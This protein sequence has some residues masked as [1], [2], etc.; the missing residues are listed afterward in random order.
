MRVYL[1]LLFISLASTLLLTPLVRRVALGLNVLTPLRDRDVHTVPRPRLGGLALTGGIVLTLVV[2]YSIPF[3][4][5][6]YEFSPALWAV[7]GGSVA[8]CLLGAIDDIWEL[9]W[10]A[11]LAGQ[12]IIAGAM[13]MMG[14]QLINIPLFGVTIGSPR[15]S[16]LLSTLILV[17][18]MNAV[19]FVDGLDGLAA[20]VIGIGSLGFF[21]YSYLLTRLM[22]AP[23]YAT[24]A[25]VVTIALAGVCIGFLWFNFHPASIFM[26]DSGAMVLGL[27][28]GSAAIIVT[29]QLNPALLAEHSV[30]TSWMPLILP[31]AVL[32]IPL[33]DL[34]ITPVLRML[35][36]KSPVTADRTHLHD[37][38]LIAGHS[39]RGVVLILYAWTALACGTA[40]A[41]ILLPLSTVLIW[42]IPLLVVVTAATLYQFPGRRGK[43][44]VHRGAGTP[45]GSVVIDDGVQVISRP[46]AGR[47]WFPLT[48]VK[49]AGLEQPE[50]PPRVAEDYSEEV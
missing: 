43:R 6:V 18:V 9:D 31:M 1:L 11:K 47:F 12:F 8:I 36:G 19:N 16:I 22:G 13:A 26:G 32:V 7:L 46:P 45:G 10:L 38:L 27:V 37:R 3:L 25:A 50:A 49:R 24:G 39:H 30:V 40:I 5:P 15:L 41:L 48:G 29:G 44:P 33:A 20:G 17:A 2:G 28:L 4:R 14:V 34:V 35:H 42:A 23:S 21:I